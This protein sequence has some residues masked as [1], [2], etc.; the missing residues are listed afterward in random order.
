MIYLARVVGKIWRC[1]CWEKGS[2]IMINKFKYGQTWKMWPSQLCLSL[3]STFKSMHTSFMIIIKLK[4]SKFFRMAS[5]SFILNNVFQM[6]CFQITKR[7][8]RIRKKSCLVCFGFLTLHHPL[9]IFWLELS[10]MWVG[11]IETFLTQGIIKYSQE[12]QVYCLHNFLCQNV[13]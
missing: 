9:V 10:S 3:Y 4:S 7:Y 5:G 8:I 2:F 11:R 13:R 12:F 1:S 6:I